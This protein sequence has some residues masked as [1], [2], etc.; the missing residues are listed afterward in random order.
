MIGWSQF[1]NDDGASN[2]EK[3]EHEDM[4][5]DSPLLAL[6]GRHLAGWM[7]AVGCEVKVACHSW[8][9]NTEVPGANHN[10]VQQCDFVSQQHEFQ[11]STVT[12]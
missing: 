12:V 10:S 3:H 7:S 9:V 6:S 8:D 2:Y 1:L 4:S 5:M 11:T